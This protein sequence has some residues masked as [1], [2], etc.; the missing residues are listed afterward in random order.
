MELVHTHVSRYF[1]YAMFSHRWG[2]GEPLLHDI[3]G[4]SIYRM[5]TKG[6]FGKLQAFCVTAC[7]LG[8]S[9]AWSDTC[10]INKHS[11]TEVEDTIGSMFVWY[12]QSALTI[13]YLSD[14]PDA[15]S[16]GSSEWFRRGWT[17]Q[18]LLAPR[19]IVFY[20]QNWTLYR[21]VT[22]LNHKVDVTLLEELERE[23]GIEFRFLTNF[24]PGMDD[25]RLRLQ[26]ASRRHTTQSEDIAYALFG[27]FSLHLP[28]LY[29]ESA[30]EALGRLLGKIILRS[31]D[32]SLL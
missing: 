17:L 5:S 19:R 8:Y 32:I 29:G 1:Q 30:E 9:W 31:G 20:T 23:T 21:E 14:I 6:G 4:Q 25:A 12:R 24:S 28:V 3:D 18:E 15:G 2:E 16:L 13:A 26:W 27:I 22:S 10:C 11:S 7:E